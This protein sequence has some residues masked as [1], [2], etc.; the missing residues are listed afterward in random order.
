[1]VGFHN[2][3]RQTLTYQYISHHLSLH[4]RCTQTEI[5][6]DTGQTFVVPYQALKKNKKTLQ[7]VH[8]DGMLNMF[9]MYIVRI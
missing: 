1:M 7:A 3:R 2:M 9:I 6:P 8:L 5:L 4:L